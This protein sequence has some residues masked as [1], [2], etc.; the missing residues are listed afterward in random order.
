MALY[1]DVQ[2]IQLY[3]FY[4]NIFK[5]LRRL[6]GW[7]TVHELRLVSIIQYIITKRPLSNRCVTLSSMLSNV[8][9]ERFVQFLELAS[10]MTST[11]VIKLAYVY[12]LRV[13]GLALSPERRISY[14]TFLVFCFLKTKNPPFCYLGII[15]FFFNHVFCKQLALVT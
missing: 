12:V 6:R 7:C 3:G 14:T 10:P 2:R 8:R 9:A 13:C 5:R 1:T 11:S 4:D 15:F